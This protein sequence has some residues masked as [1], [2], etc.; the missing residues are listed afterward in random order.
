MALTY[1]DTF[2]ISTGD[3]LMGSGT[4]THDGTNTTVALPVGSI[5]MASTLYLHGGSSTGVT[6][7]WAST[8]ATLTL[9]STSKAGTSEYV[10]FFG[11]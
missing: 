3:M 4:I 7:S 2:L 5:L 9:S 8:G 1:T 10:F 11:A 6:C